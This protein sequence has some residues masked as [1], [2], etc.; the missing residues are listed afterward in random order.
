[1]IQ[2][3]PD[4]EAYFRIF[5]ELE[6]GIQLNCK[7]VVDIFGWQAV[8]LFIMMIPESKYAEE[9]LDILKEIRDE[10]HSS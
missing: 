5:K 2:E 10:R 4:T 7:H 1:M 6:I 8:A 9:I 3:K